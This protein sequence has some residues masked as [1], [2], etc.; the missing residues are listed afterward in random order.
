MIQRMTR[1]FATC[2]AIGSVAALT[3]PQVELAASKKSAKPD[4]VSRGSAIH[5][6]Q[7]WKPTPIRTM[8]LKAGPQGPG[9][10]RFQQT[11]RCRYSDKQLGGKSPKF[12]CDLGG[13]DIVK[14][15][16]GGANGEV[17]GEVAATRLLWALGFG[18]DRM[19]P[20]RVI[21]RDCPASIGGQRRGPNETLFDPAVIERKLPGAEFENDSGWA[22]RE[23]DDVREKDGGAPKAHRDAFKL[24]AVFM[25]HTDTKDAQQRLIC[26][27]EPGAKTPSRCRKPLLMLN[28]VGLT[29]GSASNFNRNAAS[30]VNFKAWEETPIWKQ[31][32]GCTGNLPISVTGTLKDPVI[33]EQ[34]RKFLA[35][36]MNQ[37]SDKQIRDLF[38]V[39]RVT[40]RELPQEASVS[41]DLDDWVR[42]FKMKREQ[43]VS[44]NCDDN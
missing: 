30:A 42:V 18:A 25:Q 40:R 17:Y 7:V 11:V 29:F 5:Q 8:N 10:F 31:R 14:V 27:D 34:G 41:N 35:G 4:D 26:L 20:V 1:L 15:K 32:W 3:F 6:A 39:S 33:S 16:Y 36:L 24:L 2:L 13:G 37:L 12:A 9:A 19:Y 22:W 44:R 21:C 23:L 28:D 43:I 38:E